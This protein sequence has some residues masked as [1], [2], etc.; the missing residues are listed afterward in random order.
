M[1]HDILAE[2]LDG[3]LRLLEGLDRF[4]QRAGH[5]LHALGDVAVALEL[6]RELN[7]VLHAVEAGTDGGGIG[8]VRVH[9][10]ARKPVL[11]VERRPVPDHPEAGCPVVPSPDHVDRRPGQRGVALVA[12]DERGDERRQFPG[13]LHHSCHELAELTADPVRQPVGLVVGQRLL[14]VGV[15]DAHVQ[16][17][18]RASPRV[19]RLGHEGDPPTIQVGD[20]L[21]TVLEKDAPIG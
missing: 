19:V 4:P 17:A 13:E 5:P 2:D 20:L 9:V 16:V 18:R 7:P 3:G 11:H 15:P 14:A 10:T 21:R 12:V 8:Q 1:I 6:R